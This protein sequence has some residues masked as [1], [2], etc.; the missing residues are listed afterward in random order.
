MLRLRIALASFVLAVLAVSARATTVSIDSKAASATLTALQ[1]PK[2]TRQ[3][4]LAIAEMRGNQGVLRK[5]HEFKVGVTTQSFADALFDAAHGI[6]P[7]NKEEAYFLFDMIKPKAP[8]LLKLVDEIQQS[9]ERF[10]QPIQS[11]VA[12]FSPVDLQLPLEG[13]IVAAGDGGGYAFGSTDFYLNIGIMDE[14]IVARTTIAH[15]LYHAVQGAFAKESGRVGDLPDLTGMS[16]ERQSCLKTKQLFTNL[17][18]E[19][20][21]LYVEDITLLQQAQS[22]I[23]K[24]QEADLTDGIKHV[25]TSVSLLEMSV[26]ALNAAHPMAYDDVYDVGFY[27]HGVLYNFGYVIALGIAEKDGPQGL[28]KYLKLPPE[29]FVLRYTQLKQYGRDK[30]HPALGAETLRAAQSLPR[31]CPK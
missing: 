25:S 11:R 12:E 2:L 24:R 29:K 5:A 31:F 30:Q 16:S 14:L 3:E 10:Q 9:P 4:S 22:S 7:H 28:A 20:S 21:A 15:E 27:G 1:N 19:G 6:A 8:A 18:E 17:Y 13:Y 23:G 26:I